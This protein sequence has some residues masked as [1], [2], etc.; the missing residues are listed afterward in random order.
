MIRP[1]LARGSP[2]TAADKDCEAPVEATG[3]AI[4]AVALRSRPPAMGMPGLT[5]RM[6][7]RHHGMP[8]SQGSH[9]QRGRGKR[10]RR[11]PTNECTSSSSRPFV[12]EASH[13][14]QASALKLLPCF[15]PEPCATGVSLATDPLSSLPSRYTHRSRCR[16]C[17]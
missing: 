12:S 7:R 5:A 3:A 14:N 15:G 9:M 10:R 16:H 11:C 1:S 4:R 13:S 6:P 8:S 17:H 2:C